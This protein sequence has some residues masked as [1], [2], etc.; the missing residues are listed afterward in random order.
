MEGG[1]LLEIG[2]NL[3][4]M[5]YH[6]SS[7]MYVNG[8]ASASRAESASYFQESNEVRT[9]GLTQGGGGGVVFPLHPTKMM[10]RYATFACE[11]KFHE[12]KF[13]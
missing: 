13:D 4:L 6:R 1:I 5:F 7:Q 8:K 10:W 11:Y 2:D 12:A 9:G 3:K